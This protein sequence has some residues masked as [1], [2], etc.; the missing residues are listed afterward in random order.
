[1]AA[2]DVLRL[3]LIGRNRSAII[4]LITHSK[5]KKFQKS[6][7][8][9]TGLSIL[10]CQSQNPLSP[11]IQ[12]RGSTIQKSFQIPSPGTFGLSILVITMPVPALASTSHLQGKSAHS[13]LRRQIMRMANYVSGLNFHD[14]QLPKDG[15]I[16]AIPSSPF[17]HSF[18]Y[19]TLHGPSRR[20][21]SRLT[22]PP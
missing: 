13:G 11:K 7:P 8:G 22:V 16:I 17:F 12:H 14:H 2:A 4:I 18:A 19:S 3:I 21:V 15:G 9:L 5:M 10:I 6:S 1:M 20:M